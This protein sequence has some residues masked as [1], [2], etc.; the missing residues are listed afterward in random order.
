MTGSVALMS[1][2]AGANAKI[3]L[4]PRTAESFKVMCKPNTACWGVAQRYYTN[5]M[6]AT[7]QSGSSCL[8]SYKWGGAMMSSCNSCSYMPHK[9]NTDSA[10]ET[11]DRLGKTKF[12]VCSN[13]TTKTHIM[14]SVC[15]L[16]F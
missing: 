1:S 12:S 11:A 10:I 3:T 2:S 5:M 14:H 4:M 8:L 7:S 13:G 6:P 15:K 16:Q 9:T